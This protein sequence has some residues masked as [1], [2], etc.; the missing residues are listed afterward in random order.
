M[1]LL[2]RSWCFSGL[3][4][5]LCCCCYL[6]TPVLAQDFP[7][8]EYQDP[9][10]D[11][12]EG[13]YPAP[14]EDDPPPAPVTIEKLIPPGPIRLHQKVVMIG[15]VPY[16]NLKDMMNHAKSLMTY[17]TKEMGVKGARLVT[18]KSYTG[19]LES[20]SRGA[21]DFAWLG[22]TAYVNSKE[23]YRLV[24]LAKTKRKGGAAYRG[25]FITRKDSGIQG[26]EDIK[27]K[28]IGFVDPESASGYLYPLYVLKR[29]NVNPQ[30]V[31]KKVEFLKRHD[32][33][34]A[35]VLDGRIA[36]GVC[37]EETLVKADPKLVAQLLILGKTDEVPSD[38]LVC[39]EDCPPNLRER[40]QAAL[41]KTSA[42]AETEKPAGD[43]AAEFAFLPTS[44]EEFETVRTVLK[45]VGPWL[46]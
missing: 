32:I 37:L 24:P 8:Q 14:L 27:G 38:V 34:L 13:E 29:L 7:A 18:S 10:G 35:A 22:P 25:V 36:A 45:A 42:N 30:K 44:D 40:F 12:D 1:S 15:R 26:L 16:M 11:E 46:K 21:I 20:L 19:V 41:V 28:T 4:V 33:V 23:K 5:V 3:M 17:L 39:R 43:G 9:Y 31:C 2:R 6:G